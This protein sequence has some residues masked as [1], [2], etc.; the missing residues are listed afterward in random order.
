MFHAFQCV[1]VDESLRR[2]RIPETTQPSCTATGRAAVYL[3]FGS[4]RRVIHRYYTS[5]KT[6]FLLGE[7]G[8]VLVG[9]DGGHHRKNVAVVVRWHVW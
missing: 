5:I 3:D 9:V 4:K 2:A 1:G 6:T 7:H 8:G